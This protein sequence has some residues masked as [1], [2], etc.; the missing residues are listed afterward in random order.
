[1]FPDILMLGIEI[2][3]KVSDYAMDRILALRHENPGKYQNIACI[4]S[5]A[6][7]YIPNYFHKAQ[8]LI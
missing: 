4:R 8:V 3:V 7:K 6:M 2:R 5:N 1:M